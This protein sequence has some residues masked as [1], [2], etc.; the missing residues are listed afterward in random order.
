M[1]NATNLVKDAAGAT[2]RLLLNRL[3]YFWGP[4]KAAP[5]LC[6]LWLLPVREARSAVTIWKA[7]RGITGEEKRTT[8]AKMSS[9]FSKFSAYTMTQLNEMLEDDEKLTK[10]VHEMDE[11][12]Q[13]IPT[14]ASESFFSVTVFFFLLPSTLCC[15]FPTYA[16]CGHGNGCFGSR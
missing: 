5:G 16:R 1:F 14:V 3:Q 7:S 2:P 4:A 12:C 10:M 11:V 6:L 13:A 8:R 9:F 15:A